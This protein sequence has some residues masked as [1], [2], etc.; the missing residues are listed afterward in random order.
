MTT[1]KKH[2]PAVLS[3]ETLKGRQ[4]VRA[5]FRLPDDI[6]ALL[7]LAAS[8]LNLKQ[9]SIF[10]QLFEDEQALEK[11]AACAKGCQALKNGRRPKTFVLS[12]KSLLS[13]N[14]IA[15]RE[16]V[17]RDLIV[18][19][20]IQ[21]LLPIINAEQ[22]KHQKREKVYD[23]TIEHLR[24][25]QVILHRAAGRLGENDQLY[26][27]FQGIVNQYEEKFRE[28]NGIIKKGREISNITIRANKDKDTSP[29]E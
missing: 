28:M 16:N 8:Q 12:R 11:A 17:P 1:R 15:R 5:T 27:I 21:R 6:I 19:F 3:A 18:E 9:K 20:S 26:E 13:L 14:I 25:G 22:E 7:G 4:S 10:D 29:G 24:Q 2:T 23:E